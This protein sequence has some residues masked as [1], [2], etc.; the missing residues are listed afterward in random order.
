MLLKWVI[1][2]NNNNVV[3]MGD[4]ERSD[5]RTMKFMYCPNPVFKIA[6]FSM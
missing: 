1:M 5:S 3:K 6:G 4:N 2:K